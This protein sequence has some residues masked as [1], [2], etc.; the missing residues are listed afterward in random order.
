MKCGYCNEEINKTDPNY[1]LIN[2]HFNCSVE[3]QNK[4]ETLGIIRITS[5]SKSRISYELTPKFD[6]LLQN[7]MSHAHTHIIHDDTVD[8]DIVD[9]QGVIRAVHESVRDS[10][11]NNELWHFSNVM[12]NGLMIQKYGYPLPEEKTFYSRAKEFAEEVY[13]IDPREKEELSLFKQVFSEVSP[14]KATGTLKKLPKKVETSDLSKKLD[15]ELDEACDHVL[16]VIKKIARKIEESGASKK[17][18]NFRMDE[19]LLQTIRDMIM[20][21]LQNAPIAEIVLGEEDIGILNNVVDPVFSDIVELSSIIARK[22]KLPLDVVLARLLNN[23]VMNLVLH[24]VKMKSEYA[25]RHGL[26]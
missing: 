21:H 15:K 24:Y 17:W 9:M 8:E 18:R 14:E 23:V 22:Y 25:R 5:R 4:M 7:C 16:D 1:G 11:N 12:F 19:L 26:E 13:S 20:D 2:I 10:V 3:L 6:K